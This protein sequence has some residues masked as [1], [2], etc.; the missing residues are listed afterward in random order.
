MICDNQW[1]ACIIISL[2]VKFQHCV[3]NSLGVIKM[4]INVLIIFVKHV[5]IIKF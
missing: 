2:H 1:I 3:F 5:E 4:L